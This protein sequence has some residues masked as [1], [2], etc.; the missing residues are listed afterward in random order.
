MESIS[1]VSLFSGCGGFDLGARGGFSFLGRRYSR[2]RTNV[3]MAVD[4]DREVSAIYRENIGPITIA[5]V[6]AIKKWPQVDLVTG[7][8]PCQPFSLARPTSPGAGD[9]RNGIPI[10][11]KVVG[12]IRPKAFL[13]ENVVGLVWL[14]KHRAYF[15]GVIAEFQRLGYRTEWRRLNAAD[16][17]VPQT[18][19]R[20][21]VQGVR[22]DV[23]GGPWWPQQTHAEDPSNGLKRWITCR[24]A[25]ADLQAPLHTRPKLRAIAEDQLLTSFKSGAHRQAAD[26]PFRTV[27]VTNSAGDKIYHPWYDR[28]LTL[29]ELKRACSFPDSFV[30]QRRTK[31][32]GNAVPPVFAWHLVR[33]VA[34]GLSNGSSRRPARRPK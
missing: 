24:Q 4:F 13:M 34:K 10:F 21:I 28:P 3:I 19:E 9:S 25:I 27:T 11:V 5:D 15:D 23:A 7:G 30:I 8:P 26:K 29:N 31:G 14:K 2:L 18:R 6:G 20:V 1:I 32:L 33:A 17:G 12:A 16:F 22:S